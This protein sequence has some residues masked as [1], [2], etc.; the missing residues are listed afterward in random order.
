[1]RHQ[2]LVARLLLFRITENI[3]GFYGI[4][5]HSLKYIKPAV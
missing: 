4:G 3:D 2:T 5:P 1:M